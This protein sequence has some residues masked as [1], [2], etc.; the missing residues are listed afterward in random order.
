MKNELLEKA[1]NEIA[2][3]HLTKDWEDYT[4]T[5]FVNNSIVDEVAE[6][7][8]ELKSKDYWVSVDSVILEIDDSG[9]SDYLECIDFTSGNPI[10]FVGWFNS[11]IQR[12]RV[13]HYCA[14]QET[15]K[16]THIRELRD[17]LS[18]PITQ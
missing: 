2:K 5:V 3:R 15:V 8:A 9:D 1:K 12:W 10:P 11:K 18:P 6:R 16:V 14:T 13:S 7:Y 4:N 17:Y